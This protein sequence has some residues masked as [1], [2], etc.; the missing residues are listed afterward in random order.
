MIEKMIQP[1]EFR[2]ERECKQ[3]GDQEYLENV[4]GIKP[5]DWRKIT[6]GEVALNQIILQLK[7]THKLN[8]GKK[9]RQRLEEIQKKENK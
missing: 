2:I 3:D 8:Q 7:V 5:N 4:T 9:R 6:S 1:W